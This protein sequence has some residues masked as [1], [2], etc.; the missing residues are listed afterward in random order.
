MLSRCSAALR[1]VWALFSSNWLS[2]SIVAGGGD[3]GW[4]S[5]CVVVGGEFKVDARI[6]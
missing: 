1:W 4:W 5:W 6:Q 3:G 2:N